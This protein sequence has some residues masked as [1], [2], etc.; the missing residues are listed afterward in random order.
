[1]SETL[2]IRLLAKI[3]PAAAIETDAQWLLV[4]TQGARM[5]A[6]LQGRLGDAT[7]LAQGRKVIVLVPGADVLHLNPVLPALKGNTKLSQIVPYAL[8][9]QLATD[10]D[11]LHFALGKRSKLPGTPVVVVSHQSMQAWLAGL[12]EAGL[13]IDTLYADTSLL[14]ELTDSIVLLIDRGH[15]SA[16]QNDEPV[17]TLDVE[18]LSEALALLLPATD[19]PVIIYIAEDEYGTEQSVLDSVRDRAPNLEIKVLPDG[20]L[21][22]LAQQAV[23]GHAINLLQGTYTQRIKRAT[24]L[25]PWRFAAVMTGALIGMHLLTKGIELWQ[26]HKQEAA[27]D[28]Q[29]QATYS[30]GIPGASPIEP[31]RARMAFESRWQE[32]QNNNKPD[33]LMT[34][35]NILSQVMNANAGMQLQELIYRDNNVDMRILAPDREALERIRQQ[36]Q[37]QGIAAEILTA[38]PQDAKV[39][40]RVQFKPAAGA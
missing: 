32:L 1:M 14:P 7:G 34:S 30:Q 29:I 16:R 37:T 12:H 15:V 24:S 6:L 11:T 27:L 22:L 13:Q 9:D 25:R 35:L 28:Q 2:I 31:T 18:P 26:L 38:D 3:S 33:G 10:V 21:P 4:D 39:E 8:E 36:A 23:Q 5:G 20:V 40:G 19:K 17:N